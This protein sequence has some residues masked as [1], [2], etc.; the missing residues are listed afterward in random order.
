MATQLN[1]GHGAPPAHLLIK[2]TIK[3]TSAINA[4]AMAA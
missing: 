3:A 2:T 1:P 4:N